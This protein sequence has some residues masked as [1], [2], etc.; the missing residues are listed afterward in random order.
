VKWQKEVW[1][2]LI[3]T[4]VTVLIWAW[5]AGETR[6]RKTIN[7]ARVQFVVPEQ[8]SWIIEPQQ[9]P[10]ILVVEGS[11]LSLQKAETLLRRSPLRVNVSPTVG[12]QSLDLA[13]RMRAQD[14]LRE[15]GVT[16]VSAEPPAMDITLDKIESVSAAVKP[17]LPG[18]TAEGEIVI[19]PRE[20]VI[21][22]PNRVRQRLPQGISVEA[23]IDRFEL[24]QLEPGVRHTRDVK[25]RL[26]P[27]LA[28]NQDV[29][30]SP[31]SVS[32][33]FTIR[34]RTR[35]AKLENIRVQLAGPPED[36]EI[37]SMEIEPKQLRGVTIS[38]DADLIR[39]IEANEVPV[40]A[41]LHVSSREKE[42]KI[43]SKRISYF[44]ALVTEA[45]GGTRYIPVNFK[46]TAAEMPVISLK[47]TPRGT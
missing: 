13:D 9:Q 38:A 19:E 42:A 27:D 23:F 25:V 33:S 43:E 28:A 47:I 26:P 22:M 2:Y 15:T 10:A 6:E 1:T 29:T 8:E 17:V 21:R 36:C 18:V 39:R 4:L 3:V 5:A 34:S 46:G 37:Y 12:R 40:I 41:F 35:E 32:M 44:M 45:G 16:V 14:D 7:Y 11:K 30:V 24:D 31:S 20:I